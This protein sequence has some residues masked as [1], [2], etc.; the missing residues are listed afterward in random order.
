[1]RY[2]RAA[3]LTGRPESARTRSHGVR[4]RLN[5]A[6]LVLVAAAVAASAQEG[7]G[8]LT[9]PPRLE[10]GP[11]DARLEVPEP[12]KAPVLEEVVVVGR[13]QWRLPDLGSTWRETHEQ[14][15]QQGRI[16]VSF[17]PLYDPENG[18]PNVDLFPRDREM[19]RVGFI[20]VFKV[21]FGGRSRGESE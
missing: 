10:P 20:E 14:E 11:G 3:A 12:D 7:D 13:S 15:R 9:L 2:V 21:R 5:L 4:P 1:V 18:D 16:E 17:M 6:A 19:R 8:D